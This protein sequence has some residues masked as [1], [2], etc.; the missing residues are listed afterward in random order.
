MVICQ[1]MII[2]LLRRWFSICKRRTF[3]HKIVAGQ[4]KSGIS[5]LWYDSSNRF[6]WSHNVKEIV[7]IQSNVADKITEKLIVIQP[8]KHGKYENYSKYGSQTKSPALITEMHCILAENHTSIIARKVI[9]YRTK[10]MRVYSSN[11]WYCTIDYIEHDWIN[12]YLSCT[13]HFAW[14]CDMVAIML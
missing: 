4:K 6:D 12:A 14:N 8:Q 9:H 11:Q 13:S 5:W 7:D 2:I 3:P 10:C 1:Q